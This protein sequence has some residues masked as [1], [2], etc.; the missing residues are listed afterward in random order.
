MICLVKTLTAA[1]RMRKRICCVFLPCKKTDFY[2][3]PLSQTHQTLVIIEICC[4]HLT[5]K[6]IF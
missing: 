4:R 6:Q 3:V 1:I 5:Q 2:Q